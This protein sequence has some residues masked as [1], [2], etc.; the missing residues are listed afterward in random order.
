MRLSDV[1]DGSGTLRGRM[2][3]C[4]K[5]LEN[6]VYCLCVLIVLCW[7]LQIF[8]LATFRIPSDSMYPTLVSGDNIQVNKTIMGARIFDIWEAA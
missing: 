8:C 2:I 7:F 3:G 4:V 6:L 1:S 5:R